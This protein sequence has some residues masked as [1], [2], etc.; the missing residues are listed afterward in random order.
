MDTLLAILKSPRLRALADKSAWLLIAPAVALLWLIDAAMARTLLQWSLYALVL[1]GL[2]IVI[3]RVVFPQINL[4]QMV[5]EAV[6]ENNTAAGLI[7]GAIVLFVG[8]VMLALVIW[9]KA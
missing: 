8:M 3:S 1:A 9:S 7:V 5:R 6:D 2:A 4:G